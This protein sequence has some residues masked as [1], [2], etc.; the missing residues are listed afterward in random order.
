ME[1]EVLGLIFRLLKGFFCWLCY[2]L[3][4]RKFYVMHNNITIR[5]WCK[6]ILPIVWEWV[7]TSQL[8][9]LIERYGYEIDCKIFSYIKYILILFFIF[10]KLF[11]LLFP[12]CMEQETKLFLSFLNRKV[13][14]MDDLLLNYFVRT[15]NWIASHIFNWYK[16]FGGM[17]FLELEFSA[18]YF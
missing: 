11:V 17:R 13:L 2:S 8:Q 6:F 15:I 16:K 18:K 7:G 3:P 4:E 1:S 5:D 9:N 14:K 10:E 12:V